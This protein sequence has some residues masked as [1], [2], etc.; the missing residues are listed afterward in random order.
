MVI[1]HPSGSSTLTPPQVCSCTYDIIILF[2]N[3]LVIKAI[4]L[5]DRD[6]KSVCIWNGYFH[7]V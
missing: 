4:P 1:P 3:T 6:S 2:M 5:V 7:R